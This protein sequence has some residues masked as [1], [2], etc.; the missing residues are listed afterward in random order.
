M[1]QRQFVLTAALA[2]SAA[3]AWFAPGESGV[4]YSHVD[5]QV[6][7]RPT[8]GGDTVLRSPPVV[9]PSEALDPM[10][11]L[12][13]SRPV[14]P[15]ARL[16][17]APRAAMTVPAQASATVMP[18]AE[19]IPPSAPPLPFRYLGRRQD[20]DGW[21]VYLSQGPQTLI[22]RVGQPLGDAYRVD[23]IDPTMLTLTYRPLSIQQ[24]LP[25]GAGWP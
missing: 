10:A 15:P 7:D 19:P 6:P 1:K 23:A 11:G 3:L 24:T 8:A 20:A 9:L 14:F 4:P 25:I 22:A 18:L 5:D 13:R 16:F 21:E 17:S 12:A 2:V